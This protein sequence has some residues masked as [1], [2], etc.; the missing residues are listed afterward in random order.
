MTTTSHGMERFKGQVALI[1]G[2]ASDIGR[3]TA[4]RWA[5]EGAEV[6]VVD[7]NVEFRYPRRIPNRTIRRQSCFC[8][9][10]PYE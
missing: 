2:G 4:L 5:S 8:T 3:A 6:I 9:D 7:R 10:R 1:T